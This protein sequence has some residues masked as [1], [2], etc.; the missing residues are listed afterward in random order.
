MVQVCSYFAGRN[1]FGFSLYPVRT[2]RKLWHDPLTAANST[3]TWE[4]HV[5]CF[6]LKYT[7]FLWEEWIEPRRE[8]SEKALSN[9]WEA[10][11][12]ELMCCSDDELTLIMKRVNNLTQRFTKLKKGKNLKQIDQK[13]ESEWE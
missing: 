10:I 12:Q 2:F 13:F 7:S 4:T 9:L 1:N 5:D 3:H 8:E 11:K 6:E